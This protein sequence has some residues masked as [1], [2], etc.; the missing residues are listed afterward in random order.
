M[1]NAISL[2]TT[3]RTEAA[4]AAFGQLVHDYPDKAAPH[5]FLSRLARTDTP[6]DMDT[7]RQELITAIRIEP[8]YEPAQREMGIYQLA[9]RNPSL[10]RN[11]LI[12][13]VQLNPSDSA[14]QGYLGCALMNLNRA[15]E[16]QKFLAR[17]GSGV[18]SSCTAPLTPGPAA[19]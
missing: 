3:G 5:V 13:A 4:R 9:N 6:P 12:R 17:A 16:A 19:P 7:A 14:A 1:A 10:A 8:T 15:P 2:M 11:F 18:W